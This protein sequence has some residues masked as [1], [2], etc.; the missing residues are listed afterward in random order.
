LAQGQTAGIINFDAHY[1]LRAYE[2]I[3]H[4]G[5]SFTAMALDCEADSRPF[6]YAALGI[7]RTGN[8]P[9][10]FNYAEKLGAL[11]LMADEIGGHALS[12][13]SHKLA[14]FIGKNQPQMLTVDLD[15]FSASLAPGVSAPNA[16]GLLPGPAFMHLLR[17]ILHAP[18]LKSIDIAE[19]NPR[20]DT[21]NRT[22]RLG[23]ALAFEAVQA[24]VN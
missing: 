6:A 22:A 4:S 3:R 21:D 10:L 16:L 24:W 23:A 20:Y 12:E 18:S 5:N 14:Q 2:G 9:R 15:V 1:D 17:Q 11:T 8:T 7:Q 13:S 19:L